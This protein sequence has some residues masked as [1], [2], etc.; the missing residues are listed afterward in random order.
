MQPLADG[1]TVMVEV[2]GEVVA[3]VGVNEGISPEPLAARPMAALLFVH[4][5]VIPLT[6]PDKF[7]IGATTP[8]Q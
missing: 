3:L 7:V 2:M 6:G 8:A 5:N 1:V 4:A